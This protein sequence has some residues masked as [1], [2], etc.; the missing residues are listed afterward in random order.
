MIPERETWITMMG[1]MNG[2][3]KWP[4][5]RLGENVEEGKHSD[6]VIVESHSDG[7]FECEEHFF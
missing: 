3:N 2:R 1:I 7:E 4:K 6:G 5:N